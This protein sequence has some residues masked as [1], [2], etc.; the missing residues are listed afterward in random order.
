MYLIDNLSDKKFR[1]L[2]REQMF[3]SA[4]FSFVR[5]H[6]FINIIKSTFDIFFFGEKHFIYQNEQLLCNNLCKL[7]LH[8]MKGNCCCS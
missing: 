4:L 5:S 8:M 2:Y 1:L 7:I 6:S 3:F